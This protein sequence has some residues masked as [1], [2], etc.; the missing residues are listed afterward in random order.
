MSIIQ[1]YL[2]IKFYACTTVGA[3]CFLGASISSSMQ[4]T[5][6]KKAYGDFKDEIRKIH[7]NYYPISINIDGYFIDKKS[8]KTPVPSK[9]NFTMFS[10]FVFENSQL[11][12]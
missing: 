2:V 8:Y 1:S 3:D 9:W 10:T 11:W 7:P 5:D 4:A 6:L 12:N